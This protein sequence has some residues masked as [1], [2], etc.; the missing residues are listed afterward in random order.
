MHIEPGVL[1]SVKVAAANLTALGLMA[2]C[3]PSLVRRPAGLVR[4]LLAAAF[5]TLCMQAFHLKVG[6]SE[7]HFVGAMP[8]YL[9]FGLVP[10]V[11]GFALGLLIQG[12]LLEPADLVHLS[13]NTLSLALPLL[14]VHA[15]IGRRLAKVDLAAVLRLDGAYY[16][17]VTAMVGFWLAMGEQPAAL[18]DWARFAASYLVVVLLE[19]VLTVALLAVARQVKALPGVAVCLD[20]RPTH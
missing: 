14:L 1:S 2:A 12:L 13:V 16:A 5:F 10:T 4:T 7:L 19:P 20:L 8:V 17:G 6:P 9:L 18:A 3:V 15:A 11:V